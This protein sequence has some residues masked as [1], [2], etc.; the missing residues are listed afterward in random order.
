MVRRCEQGLQGHA[1][2]HQAQLTTPA[3]LRTGATHVN[4]APVTERTPWHTLPAG[5]PAHRVTPSIRN[6]PDL[7]LRG[8][9]APRWHGPC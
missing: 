9:G 4:D 7:G 5:A 8:H 6:P 2:Q 3:N 1:E